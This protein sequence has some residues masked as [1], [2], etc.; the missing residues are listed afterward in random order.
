MFFRPRFRFACEHNILDRL[1]K[2][3]CFPL[4]VKYEKN[5]LRKFPACLKHKKERLFEG[6]CQMFK[7]SEH[8][9]TFS[10]VLYSRNC[11]KQMSVKSGTEKSAA[12]NVKI[13]RNQNVCNKPY[14]TYGMLYLIVSAMI[15]ISY[16]ITYIISEST[17]QI[18]FITQCSSK[19]DPKINF[20]YE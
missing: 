19:V 12:R 9:I 6:D 2:Q 17:N 4:F 18:K 3:N 20:F 1:C 11:S 14:V 13:K 7:I 10:L 8:K 5:S 16:N 15:N